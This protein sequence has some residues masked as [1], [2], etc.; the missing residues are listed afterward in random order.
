M[1]WDLTSFF[2]RFD[3]STYAT[4]KQSFQQDLD[5]LEATLRDAPPLRPETAERWASWI[6]ELEDLLDRSTHLGAYIGCLVSADSAHEGYEADEAWLGETGATRQKILNRVIAVLG[7]ADTETMDQFLQLPV[8]DEASFALKELRDEAA[9]RMSEPEEA[10]AADLAV[11]GINAW[12][13]LYFS[14]VGKLRFTYTDENGQSQSAPYSQRNTLIVNGNRAVRASAFEGANTALAAHEQTLAASLNAIAGERL[15]LYRHRSVPHFLDEACRQARISRK[16]LDALMEGISRRN[17]L[18]QDVF[19]FRSHQLGITDPRFHDLHAPLGKGTNEK[20]SWESAVSLVDKA[21]SS[22]YPDLGAFFREMIEKR[23]IDYSPRDNKRPGGFC[24]SS[25]L[26]RESRIF[27]TYQG[28]MDAIMTLAHEAGHA[29]HNRKLNQRRSLATHY[30][31]TLAE[32]AST[33][34]EM[35]LSEGVIEDPSFS[36][37]QKIELLDADTERVLSFLLDIPMRFHFESAFY[38][39]RAKGTVPV[40][41]IKEIMTK[42]QQEVFGDTL[43]KGGEDPY[44]WASKLHFYIDDVS[45]YNY[46]YAFGYL[47]SLALFARFREEGKGFLP[48]YERFLAETGMKSCETVIADNLGEDIGDPDFWVRAIDE[49]QRP[50][51]RLKELLGT[52]N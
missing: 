6:A 10:L 14:L 11:N 23:W 30:P 27:M 4:F 19:R 34:A 33:F 29:W 52:Q 50:F 2:D 17:H 20:R 49:V 18:A 16:T 8:L 25:S 3:G 26:N 22:A 42:T 15:T 13:R 21:F 28:T 9:H 46:P 43:V 44:F 35:I 45:F 40:S 37:A 39:E 51:G 31:M 24:T 5:Q 7:A 32:S 1:D 41:R 12:S 47:L 48:G 38:T 36:D